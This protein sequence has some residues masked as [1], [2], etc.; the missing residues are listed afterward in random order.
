MKK[1]EERYSK[2]SEENRRAIWPPPKLSVGKVGLFVA[3]EF[4]CKKSLTLIWEKDFE[5]EREEKGRKKSL[6][7]NFGACAELG[8]ISF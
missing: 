4:C 2:E 3:Q 8:A 7:V 6:I 1:K 5:N